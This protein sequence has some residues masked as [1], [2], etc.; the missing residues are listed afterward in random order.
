M[1]KHWILGLAVCMLVAACAAPQSGPPTVAPTW[2]A[3]PISTATEAATH[4]SIPTNTA[5][6]APTDMPLGGSVVFVSK[7]RVISRQP[8]APG[9]SEHKCVRVEAHSRPK[10]SLRDVIQKAPT[11]YIP[12]GASLE[13]FAMTVD[14][15]QVVDPSTLVPYSL[16]VVTTSK[17]DM[18]LS[19]GALVPIRQVSTDNWQYVWENP[20]PNP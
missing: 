18:R 15:V 19:N 6:E 7:F 9:Q 5:T 10:G 4:T 17:A 20:T 8:C 16:T 14:M 3:S 1:S 11:K 12:A 2:T 13:R